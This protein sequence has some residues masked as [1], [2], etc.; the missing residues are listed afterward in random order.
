MSQAQRESI[1]RGFE[2]WGWDERSYTVITSYNYV[3]VARRAD[4]WIV[5]HR[6][7]RS[8]FSAR[9]DDIKAYLFSSKPSA[10]RR[11]QIRQ[12]LI[13]FLDYLVSEGYRHDN[14]ARELPRL[15]CPRRVPKSANS[16]IG[17]LWAEAKV[18]EAMLTA[19]V[20]VYLFGGMRRD[21]GRTLQWEDIDHVAGWITVRGKGSGVR[22][23]RGKERRVPIH[24][25]LAWALKRW[26]KECVDAEWVF[27][28]PRRS[29]PV[30]E[31]WA[32]PRLRELGERVGV[33][34]HPH[35]LRHTIATNMVRHGARLTGVRD[36]LGHVSLETT[37][38]YLEVEPVDVDDA[39]GKVN[40][41]GGT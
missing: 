15:K 40:L 18:A 19:L 39:V 9:F 7:G 11:N 16:I 8:L 1:F 36:F 29:G 4:A 21:E 10:M 12:A 20:A 22:E 34:L 32:R 25:E 41:E 33:H 6:A 26:R 5:A 30:S 3:R 14:P 13:A 31:G 23:G 35:L 38:I 24:P 27:P 28:S 17:V 37:Q 2:R